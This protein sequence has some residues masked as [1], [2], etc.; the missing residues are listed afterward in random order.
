MTG[1]SCKHLYVHVQ[2]VPLEPEV[3]FLVHRVT[4][5]KC[6]FTQFYICGGF[7]GFFLFGCAHSV[8]KFLGQGLNLRHSSD[9]AGSLNC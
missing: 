3:E 8:W 5:F 1:T 4:G 6:H 2:I 9:S 7:V